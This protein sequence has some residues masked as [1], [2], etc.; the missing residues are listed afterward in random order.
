LAAPR[1]GPDPRLSWDGRTILALDGEYSYRDLLVGRD[2][3]VR[4]FD[5]ATGRPAG[6]DWGPRR[7]A[8]H[9][10]PSSDGQSPATSGGG[11]RVRVHG[12]GPGWQQGGDVAATAGGSVLAVSP[13]G[14]RLV[15]VSAD[16][17][18]L[19]RMPPRSLQASAAAAQRSPSARQ[20]VG[21]AGA[22]ISQ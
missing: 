3:S 14:S 22:V 21:V 13:D 7:E 5:T 4:W 9:V 8:R 6:P 19:W 12:L 20:G 1:G 2:A 10:T 17:A 16:V 11:Q 15:T 18:R